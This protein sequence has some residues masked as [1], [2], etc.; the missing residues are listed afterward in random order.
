MSRSLLL[1]I[2]PKQMKFHR[3]PNVKMIQRK[4]DGNTVI[5]GEHCIYVFEEVETKIWDMCDGVK[6]IVD[7]AKILASNLGNE[8]KLQDII[9]E[10]L[11]FIV[12]LKEEE[13]I[14]Y[15]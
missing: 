8:E 13:L 10:V 14:E 7:I 2:K 5:Q 15:I 9:D 6:T 1:E 11:D 4:E 12:E 3:L